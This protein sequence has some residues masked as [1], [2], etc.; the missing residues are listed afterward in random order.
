[1]TK[2]SLILTAAVMAAAAVVLL[3][4]CGTIRTSAKQRPADETSGANK[5]YISYMVQPG[6]TLW[7]IAENYA[8]PE[9]VTV[10]DYMTEVRKINGMSGTRI[11][12]GRKMIIVYYEHE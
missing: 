7:S 8:D 11:V 3:L 4:G 12:A 1:M 9:A 10:S 2:R 5:H 6:D